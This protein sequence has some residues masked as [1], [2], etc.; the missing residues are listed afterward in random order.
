MDLA[1]ERKCLVKQK[2]YLDLVEDHCKSLD[3]EHSLVLAKVED[4]IRT[5]H[6]SLFLGIGY[7]GL[8]LEAGCFGSCSLDVTFCLTGICWDGGEQA[9]YTIPISYCPAARLGVLLLFYVIR[10]GVVLVKSQ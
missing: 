7:S 3:K 1:T 8:D 4:Q 5:Y 6:R 9:H 10:C 2:S